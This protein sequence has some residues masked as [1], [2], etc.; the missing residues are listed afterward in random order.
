MDTNKIAIY[1]E[2]ERR[3]A[4]NQLP[5]AK[6]DAWAEV[7]RR[8]LVP[9]DVTAPAPAAPEKEQSGLDTFRGALFKAGEGLTFGMG[10]LLGG[11][12]ATLSDIVGSNLAALGVNPNFRARLP[13]EAF[14]SGRKEYKKVEGQFAKEH[15]VGAALSELGGGLLGAGLASGVGGAGRV[16]AGAAEAA[17]PAAETAARTAVPSLFSKGFGQAAGQLAKQ[18]AKTG[19][20]YGGAYGAGSG[21]TSDTSG[22]D[23]GEGIKQGLVGMGA[24]AVL[25]AGLGGGEALLKGG[26]NT[27]R[28][29]FQNFSFDSANRAFN[30]LNK[31]AGAEAIQKSIDTG[32]PLIDLADKKTLRVM[33]GSKLVDPNAAQTFDAFGA[34]RMA[35][36]RQTAENLISQTFTPEGYAK[37]LADK[38]AKEKAVYEQ[39]YNAAMSKGPIDVRWNKQTAR[40]LRE[41]RANKDIGPSLKNLPD[42]DIRVLDQVKQAIDAR[43]NR[44]V[45]H[46]GGLG[47]VELQKAKNNLVNQMDNQVPI[48]KIARTVFE[49][50]KTF[51][52]GASAGQKIFEQ[53]HQ[54][55]TFNRENMGR[56]GE[57]PDFAAMRARFNPKTDYGARK[58]N[59]INWT[60]GVYNSL[61]PAELQ[62]YHTGIA[63][64]LRK[65]AES[66]T[67]QTENL[68]QKL[69]G[70]NR[71]NKLEAAGVDVSQLRPAAEAETKAM[72]NLFTVQRGSQTAERQQSI[73]QA[74]VSPRRAARRFVGAKIDQLAGVDQTAV[75]RMSTDPNYLRMMQVRAQA[76]NTIPFTS[77]SSS[78]P[79][80]RNAAMLSA[81]EL[82]NYR[83]AVNDN[84]M[85]NARGTS[86][87]VPDA[88]VDVAFN[89]KGIAKAINSSADLNKLKM[90]ENA[91]DIV[92]GGQPT[93]IKYSDPLIST[94]ATPVKVDGLKDVAVSTLRQSKPG[95]SVSFYNINPLDYWTNKNPFSGPAYKSG[96]KGLSGS[97]AGAETS[98]G[99]AKPLTNSITNNAGKNKPQF[100][101]EDILTALKNPFYIGPASNAV[102]KKIQNAR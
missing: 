36:H 18:G 83:N 53:S 44:V 7:K 67:A 64:A 65:R 31:T 78:A 15:P 41:V 48:Y 46:E 20:L 66:S 81:A 30:K 29:I 62:G 58:I 57:A 4:L 73:G 42:N 14:E 11:A 60:E 35:Q 21:L 98:G 45:E 96:G 92:R 82:Q 8:G 51:E 38:A 93:N 70:E 94:M 88:G 52:R 86:V 100:T 10:N 84:L 69:F 75:A 91:P 72:Q 13:G 49:R 9:P 1:Q 16:A 80:A 77:V 6:Q 97:L 5:Q 23:V 55:I 28:N 17:A 43:I 71:I 95:E 33:E 27:A 32:T 54:D 19:A 56:P 102:N 40:F 34:N 37:T 39:F 22:L 50:G 3:G 63:G 99:Q 87:N 90:L 74:V 89:R 101:L 25:G 47:L 61:A 12:G 26:L 85:A 2:L 79:G 59:D 24:G 76:G 68:T